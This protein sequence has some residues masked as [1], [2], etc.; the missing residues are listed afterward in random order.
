MANAFRISFYD[1]EDLY[2]IHLSIELMKRLVENGYK[3]IGF[4]YV[5]PD[6]RDYAYF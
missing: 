4:I 1:N 5:I 6:I 3:D 2:G